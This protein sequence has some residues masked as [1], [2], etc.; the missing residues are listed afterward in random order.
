MTNPFSN[1]NQII[2]KALQF[3]HFQILFPDIYKS[4]CS[5]IEYFADLQKD[6]SPRILTI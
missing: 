1:I 3:I 2:T 6:S 5:I 4:K